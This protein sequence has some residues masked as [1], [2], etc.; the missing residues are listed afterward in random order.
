MRKRRP[1]LEPSCRSRTLETTL[2]AIFG[3][4]PTPG[5]PRERR[6]PWTGCLPAAAEQRP[7]S[8]RVKG[9]T[10]RGADPDWRVLGEEATVVVEEWLRESTACERRYASATVADVAISAAS[11]GVARVRLKESE[12]CNFIGR[13]HAVRNQVYFIITSGGCVSQRC[14]DEKC[15]D[16]EWKGDFF[17]APDALRN[18]L[19]PRPS[20]AVPTRDPE[21]VGSE[22]D[23]K[24][25]LA[26][27]RPMCDL[28]SAV[29]VRHGAVGR[30]D[31][32]ACCGEFEVRD[33]SA[34][35]A[36]GRSP[37]MLRGKI[38]CRPPSGTY[39][40]HL[41]EPAGRRETRTAEWEAINH[42][43]QEFQ[44]RTPR[45]GAGEAAIFFRDFE[46]AGLFIEPSSRSSA[47][48]VAPPAGAR[49]CAA[50]RDARGEW[51]L[52]LRGA[53]DMLSWRA[54]QLPGLAYEFIDMTLWTRL[55]AVG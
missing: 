55:G 3:S 43:Q 50:V 47:W 8:K 40:V 52:M 30:T 10:G 1:Q 34:A 31:G 37:T 41:R 51:R 5:I 4:R 53:G 18:A 6:P 36:G 26:L 28:Q 38:F 25:L 15:K 46:D 27:F 39:E 49:A 13:C 12:H 24:R 7:A 45:M 54:T 21:L 35:P 23:F 42:Y 2:F 20:S 22:D 48:A 19:W 33:P 9:P 11:P 17:P 32:Q 44:K 29:I 14:W 16:K